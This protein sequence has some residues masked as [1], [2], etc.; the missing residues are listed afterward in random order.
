MKILAAFATAFVGLALIAT[1]ASADPTG[2][3][4][5][6]GAAEVCGIP[7]AG[8]PYTDGPGFESARQ[9]ALRSRQDC[10]QV[11][12]TV[13]QLTGRQARGNQFN[14]R[15]PNRVARGN[16][17]G[18]YNPQSNLAYAAPSNLGNLFGAAQACGI[19]TNGIPFVGGS[20]FE[21]ARQTAL[22]SRQDCSQ[23]A[24]TVSKTARRPY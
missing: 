3:G 15:R 16:G 5:L 6:F 18:R 2:D 23:V 19:S 22:R 10:Q 14:Y 12:Y 21:S 11:S 1:S 24:F 13:G 8:I 9:N 4:N 7:T 17:Q 20:A